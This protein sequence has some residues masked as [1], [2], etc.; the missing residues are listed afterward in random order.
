VTE[1]NDAQRKAREEILQ[2][3]KDDKTPTMSLS[4]PA[5][6][7]KTF[8][9]RFFL[10]ELEKLAPVVLTATTGKAALRLSELTNRKASTLHSALYEPPDD[11]NTSKKGSKLKFDR[12]RVPPNGT[13]LVVDESSMITPD[14]WKDLQKWTSKFGV[15]VLFI[16]DG[17][18]LPPVIDSKKEEDFNIFSLVPGPRL[19]KV[20]RNGDSILDAATALR[21]DGKMILENR[22]SY[23]W[24]K[25]KLAVVLGDWLQAPDDHAIITWRNKVRMT[26][27]RVI[28]KARGFESQFP[29]PNEPILVRK[30]GK[31]FLNGQIVTAIEESK[32]GPKM[33]PIQASWL[34]VYVEEDGAKRT[35]FASC[36]GREEPMDGAF[37]WLEDEE[38][39]WYM[40]EKRMFE[41]QWAIEHDLDTCRMDP[42]PITWGYCLT[43]HAGQGSEWGRVTVYLENYDTQNKNFLSP[44]LLP[45]G[46]RVPFWTRWVYTAITRA[47]A[48]VD[49]VIGG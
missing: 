33:G 34:R 41:H 48:R 27:N 26:A 3:V 45:D 9:V 14:V 7:G 49:V 19:H 5:G 29:M 43:A 21:V 20:M 12:I 4:G 44:S 25:A 6:T 31:G 47:K 2:W 16:G 1:L 10:E 42:I 37:P 28:R 15:K 36:Q 40:R 11:E 23:N 30:N 22:G 13:L 17:F 38:W 32:P 8:L 39:R 18:Q 35:M 24:R 46:T